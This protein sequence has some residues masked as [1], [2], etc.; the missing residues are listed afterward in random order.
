MTMNFLNDLT[1]VNPEEEY[2][3]NGVKD[4]F[5]GQIFGVETD[6]INEGDNT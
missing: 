3:L 4:L 5:S 6:V 2:D 1:G